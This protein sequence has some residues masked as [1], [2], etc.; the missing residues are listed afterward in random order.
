MRVKIWVTASD[1]VI[2]LAF[3]FGY[4]VKI[5]VKDGQLS[6]DPCGCTLIVSKGYS[7]IRHTNPLAIPARRSRMLSLV[8]VPEN[9]L[10][11]ALA[12]AI[13]PAKSPVNVTNSTCNYT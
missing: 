2:D 5:M 11:G 9:N 1:F 10:S 12:F 7:T 6:M 8:A 4:H 13:H 3:G